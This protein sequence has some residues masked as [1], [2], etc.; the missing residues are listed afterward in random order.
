MFGFRLCMVLRCRLYINS[1]E[2]LEARYALFGSD[3][4]KIFC[5][6][7]WDLGFRLFHKYVKGLGHD[8]DII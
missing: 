1:F 7:H 3:R 6:C 4:R 2:L 5:R 8:Y